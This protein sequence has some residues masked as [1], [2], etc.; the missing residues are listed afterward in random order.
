MLALV[1]V[2]RQPT[3]MRFGLVGAATL[4]CWLTSGYFGGMAVI[5]VIAFSVGAAL[6]APK[7]RPFR[8]VGG[9]IGAAVLASGL[10]G[11]ASYA[12]GVNAGAGIHREAD[13]LA[14]VRSPS[15]GAGGPAANHVVF[16]LHS[17]WARHMHGSPN[18]TEITNYLGLVTFALAI[19]WLVVVLRRRN[20]MAAITA[21]LVSAFVVGFLF[22][23]PS[24]VR[25]DPDAVEAA[26]ARPSGLPRAV[27]LGSALDDG[28]APAR[29]TGIAVRR[30][31]SSASRQ[32]S[33]SWVFRSSSCRRI[34][35][36]ISAPFRSRLNTQRVERKTPNGILAEYPLGYSDIYRLW[37]RVHGPPLVNGAPTDHSWTRHAS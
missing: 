37:Q 30:G 23:L 9:A 3:W 28:A 36:V 20:G 29:R 35:S 26:L 16:D 19:G 27:T 18:L 21:G 10:V 14:P 25:W 13:A 2:T 15:A 6:A 11:I 31:A 17:F 22:A 4:A 8:L 1:A 24:P 7:H 32:S 33:C 5:T 34:A 12:S